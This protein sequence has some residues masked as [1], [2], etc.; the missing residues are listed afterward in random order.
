MPSLGKNQ[1]RRGPI[2]ILG[3]SNSQKC[4]IPA[5]RKILLYKIVF[6]IEVAQKVCL[7]DILRD[8]E[9][10]FEQ[11]NDD[12]EAE[13]L[14]HSRLRYLVKREGKRTE[15][16]PFLISILLP[17]DCASQKRKVMMGTAE[18]NRKRVFRVREISSGVCQEQA[19]RKPESVLQSV[20]GLKHILEVIGI[21]P[22]GMKNQ[23]VGIIASFP[24]IK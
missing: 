19:V 14:Y 11:V 6:I 20:G 13:I 21:S 5:K 16:V 18:E 24:G 9:L 23:P 1:E 7:R 8:A 12:L 2:E 10:Y 15:Q 17:W 3:L 22:P 4:K